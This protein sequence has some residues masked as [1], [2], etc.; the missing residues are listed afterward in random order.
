MKSCCGSLW[1]RLHRRIKNVEVT[2]SFVAK[3]RQCSSNMRSWERDKQLKFNNS[4]KF[5]Q[6][7]DEMVKPYRCS[8]S[9]DCSSD[10]ISPVPLWLESSVI[11]NSSLLNNAHFNLCMGSAVS[12]SKSLFIS[13]TDKSK[14]KIPTILCLAL[15][16]G[17]S[18]TR[19]IAHFNS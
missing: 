10:W 3:V 8:P 13:L 14:M 12:G 5:S 19:I 7:A 11:L 1:N 17:S 6:A 2:H 4:D 16:R 9:V 18:G 15:H